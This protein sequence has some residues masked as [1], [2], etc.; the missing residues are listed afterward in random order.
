MLGNL[1]DLAAGL[2]REA[3]RTDMRYQWIY[4]VLSNPLINP[5]VVMQAFSR[6]VIERAA[7]DSQAIV[8]IMDQ[9]KVSDRNQVLMLALK[10]G[11]RALPCIR[12]AR[13]ALRVSGVALQLRFF[14][15]V[16]ALRGGLMGASPA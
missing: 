9:S 8:L 14:L 4:R 16:G 2:P 12:P 7:N 13:T 11:E 6:E 3:D 5:D 10:H 1:M 15:E